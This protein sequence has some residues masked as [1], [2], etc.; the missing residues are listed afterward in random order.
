MEA[1]KNLHTISSAE[2]PFAVLSLDHF[3]EFPGATNPTAHMERKGTEQFPRVK[4]FLKQP[5]L[6]DLSRI[7]IDQHV[8]EQPAHPRKKIGKRSNN[9]P[10]VRVIGRSVNRRGKPIVRLDLSRQ[11]A[12][13]PSLFQARAS[14]IVE[15]RNS[16]QKLVAYVDVDIGDGRIG[17]I[18]LRNGDDIFELTLRFLELHKLDKRKH[19]ALVATSVQAHLNKYIETLELRVESRQVHIGQMK[20]QTNRT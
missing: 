10:V 4:Q 12:S 3:D 7:D 13:S 9:D 16:S 18:A 5:S 17:Q 15:N 19:L 6:S 11:P 2:P 14:P 20:N 1:S 8:G